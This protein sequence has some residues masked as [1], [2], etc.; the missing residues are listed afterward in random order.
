MESELGAFFYRGERSR[1]K[2][3]EWNSA[4]SSQD[5]GKTICYWDLSVCKEQRCVQVGWVKKCLFEKSQRSGG[6]EEVSAT[7]YGKLEYY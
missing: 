2:N 6:Q 7:A 5:S 3:L 1:E 4:G